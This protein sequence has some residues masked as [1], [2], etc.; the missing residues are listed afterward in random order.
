MAQSP[1]TA[2][3]VNARRGPSAATSSTAARVSGREGL[4]VEA[5]RGR[6]PLDLAEQGH[7]VVGGDA[8]G[9]VIGGAVGVGHLDHPAAQ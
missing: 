8:G 1:R 2:G 5:D 3:P 9:G 4:E 7:H 6:H